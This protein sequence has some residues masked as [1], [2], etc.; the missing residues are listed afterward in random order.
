MRPPAPLSDLCPGCYLVPATVSPVARV[1]L[2]NE[3]S[4]KA[5]RNPAVQ[6][7]A[8]MLYRRLAARLGRGPSPR[9]LL[10]ELMDR[11]HD[12]VDYVPD[13]PGVELFQ[14]V[15]ST[16]TNRRGRSLSPFTGQVK[17]GDDCEGLAAVVVAWG[18]VLGLN[19][20][21]RWWN[22]PGAALNHVS[23]EACDGGPWPTDFQTCLPLETTIPQA[24]LGE[25]PYEALARLGPLHRQRVFGESTNAARN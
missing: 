9:E 19:T 13:P 6:A 15:L 16:L 1:A 24:R 8:H 20:G 21:N 5:A 3:E 17:G 2:L 12:F 23:A 11:V 4:R 22:Q 14:S 7:Q 25:S 10:Q 18:L